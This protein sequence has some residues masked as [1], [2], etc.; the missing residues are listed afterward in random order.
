M[1]PM[2]ADVPEAGAGA[3]RAVQ[4]SL[5]LLAALLLV[6]MLGPSWGLSALVLA[7]AAATA[8]IVAL[9]KLRGAPLKALK[10]MLWIGLG[11]AVLALF[12]GLGLVIL[13]DQVTALEECQDRAITNTAREQCL[14]DYEQA[15]L[16]LLED[17]GVSVPSQP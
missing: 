14:L 13:H 6:P 1:P 9:V 11:V 7:P 16:D 10:L 15:Y 2:P 3:R 12:Y 17:W 4:W 5:L 8:M